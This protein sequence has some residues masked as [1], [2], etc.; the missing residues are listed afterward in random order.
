M[1][2]PLELLKALTMYRIWCLLPRFLEYKVTTTV[3]ETGAVFNQHYIGRLV[4][5]NGKIRLLRESLDS[6]ATAKT[7]GLNALGLWTLCRDYHHVFLLA[8]SGYPVYF[9][10]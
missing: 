8:D 4:A 10:G 5:E 9:L 2:T 3:K 7:F 6:A 1:K